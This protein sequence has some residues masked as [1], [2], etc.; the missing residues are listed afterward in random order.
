MGYE[1][2]DQEVTK[3]SAELN[4]KIEKIGFCVVRSG[5]SDAGGKSYSYRGLPD[6]SR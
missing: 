1:L 2:Y 4:E 6:R 3:L 5:N